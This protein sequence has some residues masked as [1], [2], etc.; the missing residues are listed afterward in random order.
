MVIFC[1]QKLLSSFHV[2]ISTLIMNPL[3]H[4]HVFLEIILRSP[5]YGSICRK[6]NIDPL[7]AGLP[8]RDILS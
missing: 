7:S 8:K 5:V 4:T 3:R 6:T 1:C 2:T